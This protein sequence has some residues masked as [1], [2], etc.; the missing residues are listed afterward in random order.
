[1]LAVEQGIIRAVS[2]WKSW[3]VEECPCTKESPESFSDAEGHA[4]LILSGR[5]HFI[6]KFVVGLYIAWKPAALL[7][8]A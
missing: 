8:L 4:C 6:R 7:P 1:M 2:M 3:E 5:V